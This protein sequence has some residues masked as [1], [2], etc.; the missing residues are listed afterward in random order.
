MNGTLFDPIR[1]A[2]RSVV[3]EASE[4]SLRKGHADE[5]DSPGS[6]RGQAVTEYILI[7]GLIAIPI[8]IAFNNLQTVIKKLVTTVNVLLNGPGI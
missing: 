1:R 5:L 8:A 6:Q 2:A 7:V 4:T 3:L